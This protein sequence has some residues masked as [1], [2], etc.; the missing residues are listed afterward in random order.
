MLGVS[1]APL[2]GGECDEHVEGQSLSVHARGWGEFCEERWTK[3][4]NGGVKP[5]PSLTSEL[6]R[7]S[8]SWV[9][10]VDSENVGMWGCCVRR[11]Q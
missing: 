8:W 2:F 4:V 7:S 9:D 10:R 5:T 1:C 6:L 3:K 11:S